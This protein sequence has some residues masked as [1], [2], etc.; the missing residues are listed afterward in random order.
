MQS[1]FTIENP[2]HSENGKKLTLTGQIINGVKG[3]YLKIYF[4]YKI[5]VKEE[6]KLMN[7]K[8]CEILVG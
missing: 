5:I 1:S 3:K 2:N 4:R 6:K 8:S 7:Q